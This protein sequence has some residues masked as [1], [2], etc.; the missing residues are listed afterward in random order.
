LQ[1]SIQEESIGERM[2]S[3]NISVD[4]KYFNML[5]RSLSERESELESNIE[6]AGPGSDEAA[7]MGND[8]VYVRMCMKD[9]EENAKQADFADSVFS[10]DD[11]YIDLADL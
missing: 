5:W 4:E 6:Q 1:K 9:L 3:F 8:L 10:L 2:K 11:G 7:L